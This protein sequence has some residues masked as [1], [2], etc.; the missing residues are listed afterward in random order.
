MRETAAYKVHYFSSYANQMGHRIV[1][2]RSTKEN[3]PGLKYGG[4]HVKMNSA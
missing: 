4:S 3:Y 1:L 2:S